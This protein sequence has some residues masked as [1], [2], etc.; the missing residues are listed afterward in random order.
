MGNVTINNKGQIHKS[1]LSSH[2]E[3]QFRQNLK[4]LQKALGRALTPVE[5]VKIRDMLKK[6]QA[7][8]KKIDVA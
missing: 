1:S 4:R 5:Q 7:E 3:S 2:D 6:L 8:G